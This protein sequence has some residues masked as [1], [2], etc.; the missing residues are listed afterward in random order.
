TPATSPPRS[1]PPRRA[2]SRDGAAHARIGRRGGPLSATPSRAR[3]GPSVAVLDLPRVVD[4][5]PGRPPHRVTRRPLPVRR[6]AARCV[7]PGERLHDGLPPS[8]DCGAVRRRRPGP[9]TDPP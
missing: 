3:R 9:H 2:H 6:P 1:A 4:G 7:L 5:V 8:V